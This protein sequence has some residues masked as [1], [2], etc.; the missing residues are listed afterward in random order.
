MSQQ[1]SRKKCSVAHACQMAAWRSGVDADCELETCWAVFLL[2]Q[3]VCLQ[4]SFRGPILQENP[5]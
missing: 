5:P 4:Q 3:A 2:L 1:H